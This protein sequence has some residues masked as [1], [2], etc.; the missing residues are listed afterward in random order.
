[1]KG[2]AVILVVIISLTIYSCHKGSEAV[3][4]GSGVVSSNLLLDST[5]TVIIDSIPTFDSIPG[6]E[7]LD[8]IYTIADS[9]D[10]DRYATPYYD[11]NATPCLLNAVGSTGTCIFD[12]TDL[13][14]DGKSDYPGINKNK[15]VVSTESG[16]IDLLSSY[17]QG[18][19][20]LA[21]RNGQKKD[22]TFYYRLNDGS[23]KQLKKITVRL[24][25]YQTTADIPDVINKEIKKRR[26]EYATASLLSA[27]TTSISITYKPKRPPLIVIVSLR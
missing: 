26:E 18:I 23:K 25:Y 20:G 1:M 11:A 16:V 8:R 2:I 21:P 7:Y 4:V 3:S 24:L 13:D 27:T 5:G 10:S 14:G 22:F 6:I 19:F 17:Q 9:I 15:L 12:E